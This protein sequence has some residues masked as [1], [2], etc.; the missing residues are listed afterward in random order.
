MFAWGPSHL[1]LQFC[2]HLCTR[3]GAHCQNNLAG[4]GSWH[5][6][7]VAGC[8]CILHC[9]H[10]VTGLLHMHRNLHSTHGNTAAHST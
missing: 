3:W 9:C 8:L 4:I 10:K 5:P 6:A 7:K 1:E 2:T